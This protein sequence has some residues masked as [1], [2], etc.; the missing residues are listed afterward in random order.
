MYIPNL[1][2]EEDKEKILAFISRYS[3][4]T[5]I[6]IKDNR[7]V[8][9]HLPFV[10]EE[11]ENK[12]ILIS[13]FAKA[14]KQWMEIENQTSLVI[15]AEP[16]AYI[17][18]KH[19]EKELNVPTWNYVAVHAYGKG[20]IITEEQAVMNI[21]EKTIQYYEADYQQQWKQLPEKY[22]TGMVKGIVAFEIGVSELQAKYKLSQNKTENEQKSI[23]TALK[24]S[25]NTN[26]HI[27]AEMMES[28]QLKNKNNI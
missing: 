9:T 25:K 6:S 11:I 24:Q 27:L 12:L 8:A 3:F 18:T 14:N 16:H 19:Y 7:S 1:N 2:V 17:S 13:H 10:I 5:I 23:I 21:L 4:A 28:M 22:K 26:E 15:F 20:T